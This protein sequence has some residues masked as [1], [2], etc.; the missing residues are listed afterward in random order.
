MPRLGHRINSECSNETMRLE[1]SK[2]MLMQR[3]FGASVCSSRGSL[4]FFRWETGAGGV[5][6]SFP[7]NATRFEVMQM[8]AWPWKASVFAATAFAATRG[9]RR[10]NTPGHGE[11]VS[12]KKMMSV[13]FKR[14]QVGLKT[15]LKIFPFHQGG[16]SKSRNS[17][18]QVV[19]LQGWDP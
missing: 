4:R 3:G 10:R 17:Q 2:M 15:R 14:N 19:Q 12:K 16:G 6:A 13:M 11:K 7:T 1:Q 9:G 18:P 5:V 8:L